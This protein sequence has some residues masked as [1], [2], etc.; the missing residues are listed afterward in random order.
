MIAWEG[1]CVEVASTITNEENGT[2]RLMINNN[3]AQN[4]FSKSVLVIWTVEIAFFGDPSMSLS[5]YDI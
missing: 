1:A 4:Y 2:L 3:V 5:E